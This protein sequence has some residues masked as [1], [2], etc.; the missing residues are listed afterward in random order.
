MLKRSFICLASAAIILQS[1]DTAETKEINNPASLVPDSASRTGNVTLKNVIDKFKTKSTL[2]FL[3]DTTLLFKVNGF[4]SLGTNEVLVL[5]T[6]WFRKSTISKS[7]YDF[8]QFYKIDSIKASGTYAK[9]CET[10]NIGMSKFANAYALFKIEMDTRT[11]IL[12]W[13]MSV[14]SYEACP[15][16]VETNIYCTIVHKGFITQSFMLANHLSAGDPPS[17]GERT[18]SGI[19]NN[20][21]TF[22]LDSYDVSEDLD[23]PFAEET[24]EHYEFAIKDGKVSV[25]KEQKETPVKVARKRDNPNNAN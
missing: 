8:N 15:F 3:A 25:V 21:G 24:R 17:M 4:D 18:I 13:A 11:T 14:S 7:D 6:N 5:D 22:K 2:P 1:C 20:D 9:W 19:L 23:E 10:L 12:V 16:S